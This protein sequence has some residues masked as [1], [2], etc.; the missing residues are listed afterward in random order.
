MESWLYDF[1][2]YEY[3]LRIDDSSSILS[4]PFHPFIGCLVYANDQ[5]ILASLLIPAV[6]TCR[7]KS[8]LFQ[9]VLR[10]DRFSAVSRPVGRTIINIFIRRARERLRG[11]DKHRG[12]NGYPTRGDGAEEILITFK[13][14]PPRGRAQ[15]RTRLN[16]GRARRFIIFAS[17]PDD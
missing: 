7:S 6:V 16:Y 14:R 2:E 9:I 17:G 8:K 11:R 1:K 10:R 12:N 4:I 13:A 5:I 3:V 15:R